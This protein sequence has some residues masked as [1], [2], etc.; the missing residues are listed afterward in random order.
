VVYVLIVFKSEGRARAREQDPRRRAGL[1]GVRAAMA[2]VLDGP[3][4]LVDLDVL[5]EL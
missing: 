3:P 5:Y 4:E 1:A 2:D